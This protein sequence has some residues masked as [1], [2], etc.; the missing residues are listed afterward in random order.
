M[1]SLM[2]L[3]VPP[4]PILPAQGQGLAVRSRNDSRLGPR[5]SSTPRRAGSQLFAGWTSAGAAALALLDDAGVV[6]E[7][8]V[9]IDAHAGP[10][11]DWATLANGDRA[12]ASA[13]GAS[14]ELK[15]VRVAACV[16]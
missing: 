2:D 5:R 16:P 7:G 10:K 12:W 9:S 4:N 3:D 15:L 1:Q 6:V 13:W 14:D 11:D 8:P